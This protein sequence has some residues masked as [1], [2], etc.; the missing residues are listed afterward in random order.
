MA[1]DI[2]VKKFN[3]NLS[4]RSCTDN[5]KCTA[6]KRWTLVRYTQVTRDNQVQHS[7]DEPF[8]F[9]TACDEHRDTQL[10]DLR[11]R[12]GRDLVVEHR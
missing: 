2:I 9:S 3:P 5:P 11:G 12:V 1:P 10:A 7:D 4:E 8:W 6:P